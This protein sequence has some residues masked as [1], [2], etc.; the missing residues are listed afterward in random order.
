M[1]N[2]NISKVYILN[3][4]LENDYKHTLYF[5]SKEA[6]ESYFK[7]KIIKSYEDFSYQ[8]KDN[9]IRIPDH[10]DNLQNVN[11]VMYQNTAYSNKWFYAFVTDV[12]YID[13]GRTDIHIETD[14]M[15]TWM[16]DIT[17]KESFVEREHVSDDTVGLHTV[18]EKLETGDYITNKTNRLGVLNDCV[19]IVASTIDTYLEYKE[20]GTFESAGGNHKYGGVYGGVPT[21]YKYFCFEIGKDK[22][23]KDVLTAF[24]DEGYND[25][26]QFMFLCPREFIRFPDD[27]YKYDNEMLPDTYTQTSFMWS[28][29]DDSIKKPTLIDGYTPRNNKLFTY[30]YTYLM[31]DNNNGSQAIYKFELFNHWNDVSIC[32]FEI[33]GSITPSMDIILAPHYYNGYSHVGDGINFSESLSAGKYPICGWSSDAYTNWLT[34][35]GVNIATNILTNMIG[36]ATGVATAVAV[37]GAGLMGAGMTVSGVTGIASTLGEVYKHSLV[38]VQAQ[39]ATN[40]GSIKYATNNNTFTAYTMSIKQEYARIIDKYFDMFGYK[41]NMVKT[42][43][44][45]HRARY[46]YTK[47][48]DVNIDG[49]IPTKDMQKIKDCYNNGITFWK[50]PSDIQNYGPTNNII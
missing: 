25:A 48:I 40:N 21:G 14:Y 30:P 5:A 43:N 9:L 47:T 4:P 32:E 16:F 13:D 44:K 6:Q 22:Q 3:A 24:A 7:S 1:A 27:T 28:D 2:V 10:F 36:T 15:Q 33:C 18:P 19:I 35:N 12:V 37:P 34:Q 39:G 45:N 31:M 20:D 17:V 38:P 11:Y 8:R 42:P 50:N 49:A 29:Y 26:I 46:W 23:L 41:V